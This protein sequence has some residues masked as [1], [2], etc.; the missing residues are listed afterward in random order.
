ML[1]S[2]FTSVLTL[3]CVLTFAFTSEPDSIPKDPTP[4]KL[5]DDPVAQA[6][7]SMW[8]H[9][10]YIPEN[11]VFRDS[12]DLGNPKLHDSVYTA[13][14]EYLNSQ[15]PMDLTYN[16]IVK[17]YI[18]LYTEKRR[19]QVSR[20]LGTAQY[21]FPMFEATLDKYDMPLEL[22]Y[23]AIVESALNPRAKSRVGAKGL[24]Q[25]MYS[26]GKIYGLQTSSYVDDRYDPIKS[27]EAACKFMTSLYKIYGDWNLVLAAYN[28]GPGNV[29]KAIRRS[30]GKRDYWHLRPY[31][32]RETAGYVPAFIAVNYVM[33]YA[34]EHNLYPEPYY[35]AYHKVDTLE[36]K[37]MITFE[38]IAEHADVSVSELEMLNPA[39]VHNV[40]PHVNGKKFYLVLPKE[41]HGLFAA[42]EDTIY[43]LAKADVEAKKSTLPKYTD[44]N[45]RQVHRVRSGESLGLIANRYKVRV[46]DI[47]RWNNLRSDMIRVGQKLVIYPKN[48]SPQTSQARAK[49]VY[50]IP[51]G[52]KEE[53]TVQRG[54]TLYDIA[55]GYSGISADQIISWNKL[56]NTSLQPG[57]KLV[58]YTG[59]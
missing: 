10:S 22:K 32:P 58:I 8:A 55:K 34:R 24:W 50:P 18:D 19:G 29:N 51:E 3:T 11:T 5:E 45:Q 9:M 54:D 56:K 47:K 48:Y 52:S 31:L 40:V 17:R 12:V 6:L 16:S 7:D 30:G 1:K 42:N 15:T 26:T 49:K 38:L 13:R 41:A 37:E 59:K 44:G 4:L 23:L 36:M 39:Y 27:T 35:Y 33:S 2:F 57:M 43:A 14:M 53:Y 46:S 20:M 28:S 25:F 21:Y